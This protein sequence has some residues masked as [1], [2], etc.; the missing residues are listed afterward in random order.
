MP[1]STQQRK[2]KNAQCA[3][4]VPKGIEHVPVSI[5]VD[6]EGGTELFWYIFNG[7]PTPKDGFIDLDTNV[8]GLGLTVNEGALG[9]FHVTE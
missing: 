5:P 9:Q 6:V 1:Q 3:N 4:G 2:R 8:P 7:E